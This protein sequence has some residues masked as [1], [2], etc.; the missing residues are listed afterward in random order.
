LAWVDRTFDVRYKMT[1][2][3]GSRK[4]K[5]RS[6]N[7]DGRTVKWSLPLVLIGSAGSNG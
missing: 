2:S 5:I 6:I 3:A 4:V 1:R 7:S